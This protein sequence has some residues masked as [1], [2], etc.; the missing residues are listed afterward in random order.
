MII[1]RLFGGEGVK[2]TAAYILLTMMIGSVGNEARH[3]SVSD[4]CVVTF[5][6][7]WFFEEEEVYV[8]LAFNVG[9]K[10]LDGEGEF[11]VSRIK[12]VQIHCNF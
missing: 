6:S 4:P 11:R 9:G 10:V 1:M 2:A 8:M 5:S 3:V 7:F 12:G